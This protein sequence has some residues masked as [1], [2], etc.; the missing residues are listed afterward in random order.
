MRLDFLRSAPDE[1]SPLKSSP[2]TST[3]LQN[4]LDEATGQTITLGW[5]IASLG[6]RSFGIVLL[7]LGLLACLPGV[8]AVAGVLIAV[9]AYQM[10]R[11]R[12][13]PVFPRFL[14]MR[15]FRKQRLAVILKRA[16]PPLRYL[17]K[18]I[19]PRWQ[20][21]FETTK[22]VVGAAILLV[23][24]LL[25]A[26]VPLSN[27]PPALTIVLLA[28]AYLEE[29]GT[30]LCAALLII[31]GLLLVAAAIVWQALSAAGFTRGPF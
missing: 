12:R 28:F 9:P 31:L 7:L 30:L 18:F 2:P 23:G 15:T 22:R 3:I 17:E 1:H 25:F 20:T 4:L 26:P 10:I 21:P 24:C 19:R 14:S 29:D 8:S 13:G 11:A 6:D 27:V 5:L 16:T